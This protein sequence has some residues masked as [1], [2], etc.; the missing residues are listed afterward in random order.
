MTTESTEV[1]LTPMLDVVFILL[2]FFIVTASFVQENGIDV[3]ANKTNR[4]PVDA[5]ESILVEITD[6][7]R[8]YVERQHADRRAL[9]NHLARLHA[10]NPDR[11][12][13]IKPSS[14]ADTSSLV[15]VMDTGNLLDLSFA[16]IMP[17][18]N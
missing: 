1:D 14:N 6:T 10:E 4:E 15:H 12:L 18:D 2:I 11:S 7:N 13:V 5:N 16:I 8:F 9:A 17:S 3:T